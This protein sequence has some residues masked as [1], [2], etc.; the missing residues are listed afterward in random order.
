[1]VEDT[2]GQRSIL[3]SNQYTLGGTA[4]RFD[5][6][7]Q[8][9]LPLLLHPDPKQVACIGLA[10][11][12]TPGAVLSVRGVEHLTA[13]ELSPL[14]ARAA[15]QY[16][17]DSN[18]GVT[19]SERATIAIEDGRTYIAAAPEKFDLVCGDLF[20]P[21]SPGE[22][23]LY[24][25]EHFNAVHASLSDGGVFCQ[26]LA[27]YRL[28]EEQFEMIAE[29]FASVFPDCQLFLNHFRGD[30]PMLGLVGWKNPADSHRW[31]EVAARRIE[32]LKAAGEILDPVL[33]HSEALELLALGPWNGTG[34]EKTPLVSLSDPT[35]EFSAARERLTGNPGKKYYFMTRWFKF[36]LQLRQKNK[37]PAK[38]AQRATALQSLESAAAAKHPMSAKILDFLKGDLPEDLLNDEAA[39]WKRWPGSVELR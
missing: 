5:Q 32:A 25:V 24:S 8:A 37:L 6:E 17:T 9:L 26:W 1:M 18:Y 16:F 20:L 12:I 27:M 34:N 22:P 31:R 23:R 10:T 36:C 2:A 21:W 39:D 11:G 13:I 7:R 15:D 3:V 29:T 35:L 30:A 19:R 28:T 33:R 14:V 38:V 4:V